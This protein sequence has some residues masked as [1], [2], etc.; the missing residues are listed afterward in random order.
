M[1]RE[2]ELRREAWIG[3]PPSVE[4]MVAMRPLWNAF[5]EHA[6]IEFP[7]IMTDAH[8]RQHRALIDTLPEWWGRLATMPRTLI[9]NDFNPRNIGIRDSGRDARLCAYDWELA[10][11][12]IPQHDIA[13]LLAF[14]LGAHVD[15][16]EVE[17]YIELHRRTIAEAGAAVPGVREWRAGFALA[18]R[19]L[20]INRFGLY[21]MGYTARHW[22]FVERS[23]ATLRMLLDLELERR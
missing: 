21:L 1:D 2:A 10:T 13:E 8:L 14:V 22:D 16:N 3:L 9:H 19:D 23:L 6:A 12:H 7:S 4:S 18:A 20:L 17:H 15:Q 5:A 11:I